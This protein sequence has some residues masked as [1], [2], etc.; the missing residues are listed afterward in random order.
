MDDVKNNFDDA[1]KNTD[2]E[3]MERRNEADI[4]KK[5]EERDGRTNCITDHTKNR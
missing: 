3:Q 5:N 4:K 1:G 2:K